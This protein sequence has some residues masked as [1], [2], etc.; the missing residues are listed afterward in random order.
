M[1]EPSPRTSRLA[2]AG[3]VAAVVL[4]GGGGFLLG[5]STV[6]E[7]PPTVVIPSL[8]PAAPPEA[9]AKPVVRV[10]ARGDV[11]GIAN[12]AADAASAGQPMPLSVTAADAQRFEIYLP[13]GCD[14]PVSGDSIEP[15]RWRYDSETASLRISVAPVAFDPE[16]WLHAQSPG[17]SGGEPTAAS[18]AIEGFWV[19][20]PWSSQETCAREADPSAQRGTDPVTLPGQTLGL[21]QVFT[22]EDS[23][24]ARR[25]GKPY[26]SVTRLKQDDLRIDQGLRVRLRGRI[27]RFPEGAT[28]RCRQP[29]GKEQRP[30]CL[31]AVTF[32]DVAIDNPATKDVIATWAAPSRG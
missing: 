29:A 2:F 1:H 12:A 13:F 8:A 17:R 6:P 16:E 10:L 5:R 31:L 24:S 18:E 11:I 15:F 9:A 28:V 4:L 32:D 14:G 26:E 25:G 23:R 19:T 20:R 27:T 30:V 7:A 3:A 22:D 21:A